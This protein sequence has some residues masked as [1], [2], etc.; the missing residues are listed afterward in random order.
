MKKLLL[1]AILMLALVLTVVACT[2]EKPGNETTV[3]DDTTVETP[4]EAPTDPTEETTE[5]STNPS[6][7]TTEE[8]AETPTEEPT[9][10]PTEEPT[11]TPTEEPTEEPTEAPTD[12]PVDPET[13]MWD[14]DKSVVAHQSFDQFYYGNGDHDAAVNDNLCL[15]HAANLPNWD[16]VANMVGKNY[17]Y[18][19]YW[20]WVA[21]KSETIGQFGY[22][23]NEDTPVYD[24]A[25]THATEQPVI[26][27]AKQFGGVNGS[28]MKIFI[29]VAGL[30]GENT[31]RVLYKDANGNEVCLNK[32][33]VIMPTYDKHNFTSNIGSNFAESQDNVNLKASD[34]AAL[35]DQIN[36]GAGVDM[37]VSYN[38]GDSFYGVT[39]FTSMHTK[40]TGAYAF[41]INVVS[42]GGAEGQ[43]G[44]FVRGYQNASLEKHYFGQDGNDADGVSHGGAGI[45]LNYVPQGT[46]YAIR[47]NIKTYVEGQYIPNI[48]YVP[49]DSSDITVADDGNTVFIFAGEYLAATI[50]I[51]G[52]QDYGI[53]DVPADAL[54]AKAV[55]TTAEGTFEIENACVSANIID[56]DV[57][58]ATRTGAINFNSISLNSFKS[59]EI[60]TEYYVPV[61]L[62]NVALH[63]PTTAVNTHSEPYAPQYATDGD[64]ST[65]WATQPNGEA[66]LVVD[67]EQEYVLSEIIIS[68]ENALWQYEISVS[69]DGENY[70]VIHEG[71]PHAAATQSVKLDGVNARY[72]KFARLADDGVTHYWF[73]IY[74]LYV[75][76]VA[77]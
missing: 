44:F 56:S 1:I 69:M 25:W 27:A 3:A 39:H 24:A 53:A 72:I 46:G 62:E 48:Y 71:A 65:R 32:I 55:L 2:E 76:G 16:F 28:R 54:A 38:N 12:A 58:V 68:F 8:P 64:T 75:Y 17:E 45:Y 11:E 61:V 29:P 22:Q 34:I 7:D 6:V 26:D 70:T 63:K 10:T 36:Y 33:T 5:A 13:P 4:A 74:E 77:T 20:G 67:L 18:L 14:V 49:V 50:T 15:Y 42:T 19:T 52:T 47:I 30:E 37:F 9:E 59:V 66:E 57:G 35:F 31:L 23:F 60:P 41:N 21:T 40:P 51:T 73:S 43:A